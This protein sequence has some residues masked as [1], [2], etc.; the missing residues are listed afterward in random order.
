M[1]VSGDESVSPLSSAHLFVAA[2]AQAQ[3]AEMTLEMTLE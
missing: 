1:M 2:A 3:V